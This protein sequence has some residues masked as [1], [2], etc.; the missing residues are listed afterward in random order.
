MA[1]DDLS[2]ALAAEL[3]ELDDDQREAVYRPDHLVALAGPGSGKTRTLVARTGYLLET[4]EPDSQGIAVITY[5]RQA[6]R[7]IRTRL[8][9]F[10]IQP[11]HRLAAGT[12]HS[13]C[14]KS[15][16]RPYGHLVG[17]PEIKKVISPSDEGHGRLMRAC[18]TEA[19][20]WTKARNFEAARR[21]L[22]AGH[23]VNHD[24]VL[25]AAIRRFEE[26]MLE[27]GW[28]DYDLM[29]SQ[30]LALLRR[31]PAIAAL[32]AASYPQVL[33]DEYQDLGPVFHALV[34]CLW[35]TKSVSISAFGDADQSVM[36]VSGADPRFLG[37][38]PDR[39]ECDPVIL[40]TNYR[41]GNAIIDASK[42]VLL[43]H[44]PYRARPDRSDTGTVQPIRVPG[45]LAAHAAAAVAAIT[46][47]VSRGV[48]RHRIAVLYPGR[49]SFLNAL[50]D[51]LHRSPHGFIYERDEGIPD[52][53]LAEFIREC[54]ARTLASSAGHGG[55]ALI[56]MHLLL[57][58]YEDLRDSASLPTLS[59]YGAARSLNSALGEHR[60]SASKN[61]PL[62]PWLDH[63]SAALDLEAI[64][65]ASNDFRDR[66]TLDRIRVAARKH[67][68]TVGDIVPGAVREDKVTLTTYHSAKGR[69]WD[70]VVMPG[71]V[72][73]TMPARWMTAEDS[74]C[75]LYVG[76]TRAKQTAIL[77]HGE[78]SLCSPRVID[79]LRACRGVQPSITPVRTA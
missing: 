12:L 19:R 21:S 58:Q 3:E 49:G 15:I 4:R 35:E 1:D 65:A 45:D 25:S 44:R 78:E 47:S 76:I 24:A 74:R 8:E 62:E 39:L 6:A 9:R 72:G 40:R 71:L 26:S 42:A 38:L 69:E 56:P 57:R 36:T 23:T 54:A 66:D 17:L 10:G 11:E 13:W 31:H 46:D 48:D 61:E 79:I 77:I 59:E 27:R 29:A 60:G 30:A 20:T 43:E 70:V 37:E 53:D 22:A 63:L 75:L 73:D 18:L 5:T 50:L 32:V 64:A 41:S 67:Q 68:L 55:S 2:P 34:L 7:V 16:L 33:V 14:V 52:G 28:F 51:E